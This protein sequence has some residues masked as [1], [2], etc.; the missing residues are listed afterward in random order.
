MTIQ[1]DGI[2]DY[3]ITDKRGIKIRNPEHVAYMKAKYSKSNNNEDNTTSSRELDNDDDNAN[4]ND[5]D[6]DTTK[7]K[8]RPTGSPK[9]YLKD[10]NNGIVIR[11]PAYDR[12]MG[13]SA[14]Q[15]TSTIL[16]AVTGFVDLSR[17]FEM[18]SNHLVNPGSRLLEM[19]FKKMKEV[20]RVT[21]IENGIVV[22]D[23]RHHGVTPQDTYNLFSSTKS[24]TSMLIGVL[25]D[26][27]DIE[28]KVTDTL[29]D[30]FKDNHQAWS[31]LRYIKPEEYDYKKSIRLEE[32]LTMTSGLSS[33]IGGVQGLLHM[34]NI[35]VADAPGSDLPT[36]LVAPQYDPAM[37][38]KF[39]YMPSS[40]I[41]SYVI[42]EKSGLSPREFA[43]KFVFPKL[44][45]EHHQMKWDRNT[46][47]IETSY[48][49][50]KL[51]TIHM[52]K[53]GQLYLQDGYHSPTSFN[54]LMSEEW[55]TASHSKHVFDKV[56]H[57]YGYLWCMYDR[58]F[59]H[60]QT[61]G[62]VWCAPGFNGQMIAMSRE[63][64]RVVA[65]SRSPIPPLGGDTLR[66]K[67]AVI[68]LLSPTMCY[69]PLSAGPECI[70]KKYV[71]NPRDGKMIRNEEYTRFLEAKKVHSEA[72]SGNST[73]L[74]LSGRRSSYTNPYT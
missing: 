50:L 66:F 62:D 48:S 57:W 1:R 11:N 35:S 60:Q 9:K 43:D 4:D 16:N 25:M 69:K 20:R 7:K 22:A 34:Q 68:K 21:V 58:K 45:I 44:G 65:I 13:L 32:I 28:L 55:M 15:Q 59:H 56:Y 12:Y 47:G 38:G 64:N 23:Y 10:P 36:S 14:K 42:K 18:Q 71:K 37:R 29:G 26:Q 17:D 73:S 49:Q 54:P 46:D 40:N 67:K 51:T 63:T 5:D 27:P 6:N 61:L 31:R 53:V 52:C 72:F 19:D 3:Y 30:I 33:L 41:L 24:I 2:P 74:G 70:P 39:N 8:E